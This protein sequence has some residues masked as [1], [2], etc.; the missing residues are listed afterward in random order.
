MLPLNLFTRSIIK[1][2]LPTKEKIFVYLGRGISIIDLDRKVW[3]GYGEG[4]SLKYPL[5]SAT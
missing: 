1:I 2:P 3:E 5:P 4:I